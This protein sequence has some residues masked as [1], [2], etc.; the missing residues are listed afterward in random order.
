M[1]SCFY[2]RSILKIDASFVFGSANDLNLILTVSNLGLY[3]MV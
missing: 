2:G 3:P 1:N